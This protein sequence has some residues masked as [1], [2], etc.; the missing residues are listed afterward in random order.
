VA[1][2]W[3]RRTLWITDL[4]ADETAPVEIS[5]PAVVSVDSVAWLNP[6]QL[7][8]AG[9]TAMPKN[10]GE[11]AELLVYDI[12]MHEVVEPLKDGA[13]LALRG[14]SLSASRDGDKIAFVTYTDQQVDQYGMATATETLELLGR[15]SGEVTELGSNEAQFDVNAR[16]FDEPLIAPTGDAII[17][18]S[19]GSDVGT[20]YTVLDAAGTTLMPA[21]KLLYPAGYAWDPTGQKVVFTGHSTNWNGSSGDPTIFYVF[22][23]ATGGPPKELTRYKKTAVQGLSW[24]PDGG[25]IA[26]AEWDQDTYATGNIYELSSSGG[27]ADKLAGQAMLPAYQ[28]TP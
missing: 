19:A 1:G 5:T 9:F 7:L 3:K 15:E 14:V 26:F 20:S 21:K 2:T 16:S 24:S 4:A 13:G 8:V 18:R 6:R 23:R 27:D 25:K 12:A 22:D 17:F 28:P 11:V 10:Q